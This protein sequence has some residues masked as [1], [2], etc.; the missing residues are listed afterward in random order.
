MRSL[1][2][3]EER[4]HAL[5]QAEDLLAGPACSAEK[6]WGTVALAWAS[7]MP[8][9]QWQPAAPHTVSAGGQPDQE[10]RFFPLPWHLSGHSWTATSG[11]AVLRARQALINLNKSRGGPPRCSRT[12]ALALQEEMGDSAWRKDSFE[13]NYWQPAGTYGKVI[14]RWSLALHSGAWHENERQ[15]V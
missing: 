2:P 10:K 8:G 1:A 5:A 3:E 9:Q 13:R 6:A 11:S 14:K 7:S 12:W 4:A 15:W